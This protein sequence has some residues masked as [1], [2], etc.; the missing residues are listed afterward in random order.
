[1][2]LFFDFDHCIKREGEDKERK[3]IVGDIR[4]YD[5]SNSFRCF[6][7]ENQVSA[8]FELENTTYFFVVREIE[9]VD[10]VTFDHSFE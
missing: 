8:S 9:D 4:G 2:I 5:C 10:C 6:K 3:K 7:I 1:M